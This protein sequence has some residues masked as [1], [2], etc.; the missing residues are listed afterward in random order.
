MVVGSGVLS[1][2]RPLPQKG[3][4]EGGDTEVMD[5]RVSQDQRVSKDQRVSH[6]NPIPNPKV[7]TS[8]HI[9]H[10]TC[11]SEIRGAT[12]MDWF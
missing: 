9:A 5:Q 4:G 6:V 2:A 8:Q 7:Q 12:L 11:M 1:Q 10:H 3:I